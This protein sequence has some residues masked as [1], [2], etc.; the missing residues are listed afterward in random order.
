MST[1]SESQWCLEIEAY[2]GDTDG[3]STISE[4][5]WCLEIEAYTG[6]TDGMSVVNVSDVSEVLRD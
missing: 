6:D 2:T 5:Q 3:V 4:S 1:I